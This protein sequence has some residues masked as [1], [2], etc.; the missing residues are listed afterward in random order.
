[1]V[2][3]IQAG[4]TPAP[5][6]ERAVAELG[7]DSIIGTVLNRVDSHRIPQSDYYDQYGVYDSV[8]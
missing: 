1:V 4:V 8:K 7:A 2:L 3:V 6:V 5:A